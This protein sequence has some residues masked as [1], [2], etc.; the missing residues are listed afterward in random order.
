M[1]TKAI[2]FFVRQFGV[3][4]SFYFKNLGFMFRD[5]LNIICYD[6]VIKNSVHRKWMKYIKQTFG[7]KV[8]YPF[9]FYLLH[10]IGHKMTMEYMTHKLEYHYMI[11]SPYIN[12]PAKMRKYMYMKYMSLPPEFLA[13]EWAVEYA[14]KHPRTMNF[15]E[16]CA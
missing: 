1:N 15:L 13:T 2:D 8:K 6:K 11:A 5:D 7:Y 12:E 10:E 9:A 4:E 16:K 3:D 14:K